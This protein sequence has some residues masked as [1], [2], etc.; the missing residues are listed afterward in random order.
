MG[1]VGLYILGD[2]SAI[3]GG[4][5]SAYQTMMVIFMVITVAYLSLSGMLG[6]TK[7]MVL[8][9]VILIVAFLLGLVVTGWSGGFTTVL[10][11]LEYG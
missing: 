4:A 2:W 11:Q 8:Q 10:P 7:N 3:T 1:L 5:L 9:Y 6:A